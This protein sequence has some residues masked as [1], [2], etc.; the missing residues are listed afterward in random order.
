MND[1]LLGWL[2]FL[3]VPL[4]LWLYTR[5]PLGVERSL[6]LGTLIMLTHPLY[7]RP[8]ALRRAGRRCLWCGESISPADDEGTALLVHEPRGAT[9]WR[10]CGA[11]HRTRL[12]RVLLYATRASRRLR[13]GILGTLALFLVGSVL[14]DRHAMGGILPR[15]TIAI[16]RLG[17]ALIVLPL[18]WLAPHFVAGPAE[19]APPEL[20]SPFP[21][22]LQALIGTLTVLWLF[23]MVGLVWLVQ[24]LRH[25]GQRTGLL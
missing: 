22:H 18:G 16:F 1:R 23:R 7:A 2:L 21:V 13:F 25:L 19:G 24:G 6:V 11:D 12:N 9:T 8:F 15:D 3:P 4:V 17:V 20:R 5:Q 10:T 14:A